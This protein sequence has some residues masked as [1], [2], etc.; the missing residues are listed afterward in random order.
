MPVVPIPHHSKATL[1]SL[2]DASWKTVPGV[3]ISGAYRVE[4]SFR[5]LSI[6]VDQQ[7]AVDRTARIGSVQ[8]V[9][10]L[11]GRA[12]GRPLVG[13]APSSQALVVPIGADLPG[14][15]GRVAALC[16]GRLPSVS[17]RSRSIAYLAVPR[18]IA[19]GLNS[20]LAG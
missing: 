4:Q 17:T 5:R 11:A 20:L 19:N 16:S 13:Y 8:L 2:R 12:G 18:D 6:W 3:G 9:K 10:H 1:F 15:Y 7:G 14:L